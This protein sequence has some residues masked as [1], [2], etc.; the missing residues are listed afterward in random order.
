MLRNGSLL[1]N[2]VTQDDEAIYQCSFTISGHQLAGPKYNL[3]L[4]D[5]TAGEILVFRLSGNDG[6]W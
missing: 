1:I 5:T 3:S 2:N 4:T 6:W